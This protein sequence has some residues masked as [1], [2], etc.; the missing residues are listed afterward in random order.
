VRERRKLASCFQGRGVSMSR[1]CALLGICRRRLKYTSRRD[2]AEL[3]ERLKALAAAHP[4]MGA[5]QLWRMLRLDGLVVNLKRVRRLCRQHG[6]LLKQKRRRKRRGIGCGMPCRAAYP[7]HVWSYDFMEDRTESGRKLRILT[8]VDEFTRRSLEVEVE[9]RMNAKFVAQTLLK[10]FAEHGA[11]MFIRSDNGPEFIAKFLMRVL[12]IHGVEARHIDPG[13]PWQ[14]GID[15]RFN[16]TLRE[17]CLNLETFHNRDHARVLVKAYLRFYNHRRPHSSLG[18]AMT[19]QGFY[20]RWKKQQ[21]GCAGGEGAGLCPGPRDL[22]HC[23]PPA[24]GEEEDGSSALGTRPASR[25]AIHAGAPVASQ[26]SR[27]LRVDESSI[28]ATKA[29]G[30]FPA[31]ETP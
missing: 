17:E 7:N 21:G 12:K 30:A 16:G 27:I 29:S 8:V 5:R 2:D 24:M 14:N 9:H 19:P 4:R 23:G 20:E 13:S 18:R 10:L 31:A 11:P 22:S 6:L 3:V 26:Q 28:A 25:L 1:A 15:E